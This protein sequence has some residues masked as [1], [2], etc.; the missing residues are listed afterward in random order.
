VGS[1]AALEARGIA[2]GDEALLDQA[3]AAW[4]A[5]SRPVDAE[6]VSR[7]AESVAG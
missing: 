5:L 2:N 4:E 3:R 1:A 7:L 6:R